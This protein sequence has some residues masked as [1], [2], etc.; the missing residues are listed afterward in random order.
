MH[1][2]GVPFRFPIKLFYVSAMLIAVLAAVVGCTSATP[3]PVATAAP[4]EAAEPTPTQAPTPTLPPTETPGPTATPRPTPTPEPTATPRPTPTPA[5]TATPIPT[6]TPVPTPAPI[7]NSPPVIT[8]PGNKNYDQGETI[9][10]FDI[11]VTDAEDTPTVT[12]TGLPPGLSYIS[13]EISG[14]INS[15]AATKDYVVAV[16]ADDGSNPPA[17]TTFTITV[18]SSREA[19]LRERVLILGNAYAI[20]DW[21]TMYAHESD[22]FKAKCSLSEYTAY[23]TF[24]N[25]RIGPTIP[26]SSTYVLEAVVIEEDYA[27]VHSHFVKD[28]Q[29]IFHDEDQRAANERPEY[30]WKGDHW[31]VNYTPEY[32]ALE[33][34]CSL[35]HYMGFFI[36]LPLS[37]G[38]TMH[39]ADGTEVQVLQT[40]QN[41]W[42]VIYQE[43]QF[44]D[45]PDQGK[46]FFMLRVGMTNPSD[47]SRS[48]D[49]SQYKFNL[50]GDNR[51]VY[52]QFN[53][54]C[55]A[56][57]PDALDSEIF[58]GGRVE[59]NICFEIPQGERGLILI[60]QPWQGAEY[61]RF[62]QITD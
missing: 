14:T 51:V 15:D 53:S 21:P 26:Q 28:G 47:S 27:W 52:T 23:L 50:I 29:Q 12:L 45:P 31:V 30:V 32:L 6:P 48:V 5:P 62:L 39:G 4:T 59:G 11:M 40:W 44:N 41:A 3:D 19:M 24:V 36:D 35:E 18:I 7:P 22:D 43:N 34:P 33:R 61:R 60:H 16:F 8:N 13:G 10:A 57:I 49:A 38:S 2:A 9:S 56:V 37:V 54:S 58:P 42:P 17:S 55:S 20:W 1:K 46:H 25:D